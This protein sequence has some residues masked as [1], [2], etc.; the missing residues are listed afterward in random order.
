MRLDPYLSPF[1][2]FNSK[3]TNGLNVRH[4]TIKPLDKCI[5][6][7]LYSIRFD[8]DFLNMA[9]KAQLKETV[10]K[11]DFMNFFLNFPSKT[12]LTGNL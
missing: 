3:W 10:D 12:T 1:R 8:N 9:P 7:K 2:T 6:Q 4:E 11:L 5:G